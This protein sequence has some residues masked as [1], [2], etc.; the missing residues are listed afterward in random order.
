V[1]R[2]YEPQGEALSF[3]L[4]SKVVAHFTRNRLQTFAALRGVQQFAKQNL[5]QVK[6]FFSFKDLFK[7]AWKSGVASAAGNV[8]AVPQV[9]SEASDLESTI[10]K[11][12]LLARERPNSQVV[13]MQVTD[14]LGAEGFGKTKKTAH[15]LIGSGVIVSGMVVK[16]N[17]MDRA[18][19]LTG[20][21]MSPLIGA[22]FHTI[23]YYGKKTGGEVAT[24]GRPEE[25]AGAIDRI[26]TGLAARYSLGFTLAEGEQNDDREH[27][28]E[29][30]VKSRRTNRKLTVSSR[31]SYIPKADRSSSLR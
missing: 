28:L 5:P 14:D 8:P 19:N 26:V 13:I 3:Q 2:W 31:R 24:V 23:S 15:E 17:L 12:P 29:V 4:K 25:F 1:Q 16:R 20:G 21:I 10:D 18:I 30:K 7:G 22:R 9:T 27:E 11:A 6:I